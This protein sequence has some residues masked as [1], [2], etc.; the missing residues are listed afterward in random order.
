M[1]NFFMLKNGLL[2]ATNVVKN[3]DECICMYSG[4]GIAFVGA[5]SWSFDNDFARNVVIF[6]VDNK[7]SSYSDFCKKSFFGAS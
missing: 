4:Y 2:G 5:V 3:N 7:S 1:L 6:G